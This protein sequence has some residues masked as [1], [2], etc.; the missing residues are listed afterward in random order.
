MIEN[1]I[2]LGLL[3]SGG[4][5]CAARF[6]RTFEETLPL[7]AMGMVL[8]VFLFGV[9]GWLKI[10]VALCFCIALALYVATVILLITKKNFHSFFKNTITP[11]SLIFILI[12]FALSFFNLGR[13]ACSW[14]EFSH[15]VD[16]V[17]VMTTLND[18]G[19]NPASS[20]AFQS[21]PPGMSIFQYILQRKFL[22]VNPDGGFNEWRVF[23]SYQIFCLI[24]LFPLFKNCSFKKPLTF[25]LYSISLF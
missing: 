2:F 8:L 4:V 22:W 24:P 6:N 21:Y 20:S 3:C 15:W 5:W 10:G 9:C 25:T 1:I 23:F 18:F 11:G 7:T 19:T 13:V 17:K 16:I 14:D 12:F